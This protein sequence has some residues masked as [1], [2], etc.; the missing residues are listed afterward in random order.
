MAR[1]ARTAASTRSNDRAWW[2]P[3][4][5]RRLLDAWA[6]SGESLAAFARAR[7]FQ[8]QRLSWWKKRVSDV[9]G[10]HRE[11]APAFIPIA[12]RSVEPV[13]AQAEVVVL[14]DGSIRVE[15]RA[16]HSAAAEWVAALA[17]AVAMGEAP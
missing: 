9:E 16:L 12:I 3:E 13:A 5:A 15:L 10:A 17:R 6:A 14:R 4:D 8:P 2:S 11:Q 1:R 7:G